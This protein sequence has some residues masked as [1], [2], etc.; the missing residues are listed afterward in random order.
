LS[1]QPSGKPA[2]SVLVAGAGPVGLVLASELARRG[3]AVRVVDAAQAPSQPPQSRAV[4][5]WP[6]TLELLRGIGAAQQLAAIG[7]RLDAIAY[8]SD[9]RLLGRVRVGR[10]PDTPYPYALTLPQ[11]ATEQVL[12]ESLQA[13]G[14]RVERG[15][16]VEKVTMGAVSTRADV[17]LRHADGTAEHVTPAWVVGADGAHSAIRK[18][19]GIAFEDDSVDVTFGIADAPV[20]GPVERDTLHYC[21]TPDGA[22]GVVPLPGGLF[23]IAVSIP[24]RDPA[25]PPPASVFADALRRLAPG[26]GHLGEPQWTG[27]F[28]VR[29][30]IAKSFRHGRVFLAG[31]AAHVI[32]PAGGQGM[33]LGIQDAVNLGW[34]LAAVSRSTM[35]PDILDTYQTERR[36]AARR[37]A[38]ATAAQTRWG[39]L[40]SRPRIAARDALVRAAA[41]TGVLQRVVAPL[42]AQT[43]VRYATSQ[44]P[45]LRTARLQAGMRLPVF[46]APS[47]EAGSLPVAPGEPALAADGFTVLTSH[48]PEALMAALAEQATV[49]TAVGPGAPATVRRALGRKA[50]IVTIRPD[51]HIAFVAP[52]SAAGV[53]AT[54]A[55]LATQLN[56]GTLTAAPAKPVP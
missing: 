43:D 51:G 15:T 22:I 27:S 24:H 30:R 2:G 54:R 46:G 32:S 33:N 49:V 39:M 14:G 5:I 21:Y 13:C 55:F 36:A 9:G 16:V 10:L 4:L 17:L 53:A 19:L 6:R 29:C 23:R 47:H 18:E 56:P 45:A 41:A 50:V 28:R 11:Y 26:L 52:G 20:T 38:A 31:D 37:V 1:V 44:V 34:K 8:R 12:L 25:D 35:P 48:A 7:H 3:V 42:M 40:Q